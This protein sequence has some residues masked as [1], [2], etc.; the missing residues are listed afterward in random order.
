MR[1][2]NK[3]QSTLEY[4]IILTAIIAGIIYAATQFLQPR[5]QSS[6]DSATNEMQKQVGKI[7]F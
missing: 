7:K 2:K 6:L 3:G 4:V 5:V 1:R